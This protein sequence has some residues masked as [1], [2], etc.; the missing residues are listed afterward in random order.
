MFEVSSSLSPE[1]L[2]A[3]ERM[4][5]SGMREARVRNRTTSR[6]FRED[7]L[8]TELPLA[9]SEA[10]QG[11]NLRMLR[12]SAL[13]AAREWRTNRRILVEHRL[14]WS[15]VAGKPKRLKPRWAL[16]EVAHRRFTKLFQR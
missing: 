3:F 6:V 2:L 16:E 7:A 5:A 15:M 9:G 8:L 11:S 1:S 10:R 12:R 4:S 13:E 14:S